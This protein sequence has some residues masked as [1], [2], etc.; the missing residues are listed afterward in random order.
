MRKIVL[1]LLLGG[2]GLIFSASSAFAELGDFFVTT[3]W[4]AKR[5]HQVKIVDV[6]VTP[7]YL[8]G[9][10]EGALSIPKQQFL[11]TRGGVKSLV[12]TVSEFAFLMDRYGIT[13]DTTVVAY[14]EDDNPYAA[15]FI[16]TLRYHGHE[17]SY[18]LDGGFNKWTKEN[19]PTAF[20]PTQVV[21]TA[22]YH[23]QPG[24]DIRAETDYILTRLGN[25]GVMVWD[26][27]SY[28][29]FDG[30]DI[31]AERGGHIP[32]A[33]HL[34]WTNLQKEVDGVRV[35]KSEEEIRALLTAAG[36]TPEQDI[37]A[38]CQTGIRSSY[39]TLVL[40]GLGYRVENYDGSWI[41]W[42]NNKALPVNRTIR[43]ASR[44][45]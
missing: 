36:I 23:C 17:R 41:E 8:L 37:V 42:A 19:G 33:V 21:P 1:V 26:T 28:K 15:R 40:L 35:L 27:R 32:G 34:E 12:P 4:L 6:R 44:S 18:V 45:H 29:E 11:S 25:P 39:A 38:H 43:T 20:L 24:R 14:A 10:I 22:G 13:P 2:L 7:M 31:R 3:D 16:W 30:S 5:R 9:H